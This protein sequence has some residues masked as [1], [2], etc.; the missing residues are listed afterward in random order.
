M[1]PK[2][3]A[4]VFLAALKVL[5]FAASACAAGGVIEINQAVVNAA[6]G[7]PYNITSSGS[8][9]LSGNLT[10]SSTTADA[11]D[12]GAAA[13]SVTI[14]LNGFSI[15]GPGGPNTGSG[16]LQN[17]PGSLTVENGSI[18]GFSGGGVGGN[19]VFAYG[20][21]IVRNMQVSGNGNGIVTSSG[22]V[23]SGNTASNNVVGIDC[24][25][26]GCV[27]SGNTAINNASHGIIFNSFGSLITGNAVLNNGGIGLI[28]GDSTNAYGG[29][30]I[31]GNGYLNV[32][33]GT[34]LG[35]NLCGGTIC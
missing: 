25:G 22:S 16:I 28:G 32:Q 13:T 6:G 7:F 17:N 2:L 18:N 23:I 33:G 24:A 8:Y 3:L 31:N 14:D 20:D 21:A 15:I 5:A 30:V 10:D 11:I 27:I 35:N 12:I 29:N 26:S 4:A 34:S 19:G 9:R 1:K